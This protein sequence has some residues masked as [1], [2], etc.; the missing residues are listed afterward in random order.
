MS[1]SGRSPYA[2]SMTLRHCQGLNL[3]HYYRQQTKDCYLA[4]VTHRKV[5]EGALPFQ[6]RER[7]LHALALR[8]EG[9]PTRGILV[10]PGL[11]KKFLVGLV[12]LNYRTGPVLPLN[13]P[14]QGQ[15]AVPRVGHDVVGL[16]CPMR[17]SSLLKD[18]GCTYSVMDVSGAD[19]GS[20]GKFV[21]TVNKKVELGGFEP[22][23]PCMQGRCSPTE[24]QPH[25]VQASIASMARPT[26]F[27]SSQANRISN[28]R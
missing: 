8:I 12:H 1:V 24:L 27:Y 11:S 7:T 16:E 28:G 22:P 10:L 4:D 20:Y 18:V 9:F 5:V 15:S 25:T 26:S 3:D 13:Q 19:I 2:L 23:T 17:E 6:S 21:L 14:Y